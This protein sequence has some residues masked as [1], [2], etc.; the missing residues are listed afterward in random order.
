MMKRLRD[1]VALARPPPP[2]PTRLTGEAAS[3]S[4]L[5][6]SAPTSSSGHHEE[7][8]EADQSEEESKQGGEEAEGNR[9]AQGSDQEGEQRQHSEED[10]RVHSDEYYASLNALRLR[11]PNVFARA[12]GSCVIV[13]KQMST[14]VQ[15]YHTLKEIEIQVLSGVPLTLELISSKRW[16]TACGRLLPPSRMTAPSRNEP[17]EEARDSPLINTPFGLPQ[18]I[19]IEEASFNAYRDGTRANNREQREEVAPTGNRNEENRPL[20][21]TQGPGTTRR[22]D[23]EDDSEEEEGGVAGALAMS[24][25]RLL[26]AAT[27][28]PSPLNG[29]GQNGRTENGEES[30]G[31]EGDSDDMDD[32]GDGGQGGDRE[33]GRRGS[34]PTVFDIDINLGIPR[35]VDYT[36]NNNNSN[37]YGSDR[38]GNSDT[39]RRS[40][41]VPLPLNPPPGS[42]LLPPLPPL[43]SNSTPPEVTPGAT[44]NGR[45]RG[46]YR[47]YSVHPVSQAYPRTRR[48]NL[49]EI[50]SWEGQHDI[51][52]VLLVQ[53][54]TV[55]YCSFV[56][57][58]RRWAMQFLRTRNLPALVL[59]FPL[60]HCRANAQDAIGQRNNALNCRVVPIAFKGRLLGSS[61]G[62][63]SVTYVPNHMSLHDFFGSELGRSFEPPADD[64]RGLRHIL[65]TLEATDRGFYLTDLRH[66]LSQF[67]ALKI[68]GIE[69]VVSPSPYRQEVDTLGAL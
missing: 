33:R 59:A 23:G 45:L 28:N 60:G 58:S 46:G 13:T 47:T 3:R 68:N 17:R 37:R 11:F 55:S 32:M 25:I 43:T 21:D 29:S 44:R 8:K 16:R 67:D 1:V 51:A 24:F 39:T 63:S 34:P 38:D 56:T 65:R 41:R 2:V 19:P 50:R 18:L 42:F 62:L 57:F 4:I 40:Q 7:E 9:E 12:L 5:S 54:T 69:D 52:T 49:A 10:A 35:T 53:S 30:D 22:E 15:N 36:R 31:D 20:F 14:F 66:L 27:G 64:N 6:I 48:D 61:L 26:E